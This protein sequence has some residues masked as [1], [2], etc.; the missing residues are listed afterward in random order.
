MSRNTIQKTFPVLRMHCA[1]CAKRIEDALGRLPGV[2]GASVNLAASTAT[3]VYDPKVQN[4]SDIRKAVREEG[5]DL[6]VE[7]RSPADALDEIYAGESDRLRR[8]MLGAVL[9]SLP[10]VVVSM[11]F[12]DIPYAGELM[13]VLATPVVF[14]FGRDFFAGAWAQLKRRSASMDTLVAL[15]TATAYLFSVF[16]TLFPGFWLA[17]GIHPHVYFESAS[18]I[19]AFVLLGRWLEQ[20]ARRR[21]AMSV[22]RLMGLQPGTATVVRGF[23]RYAEVTIGDLVP[24]DVVL[25]KPGMRIAVDG[26]VMTGHS[27]VDESMLTG[28]P[29]PVL[30]QKGNRVFAGTINRNGSLHFEA[31][32]T[33]SNTALAQIIRMVQDAQGSKAPVQKRV[34]RIAAVFV[35]AVMAIAVIALVAWLLFDAQNGLVHGVLALVTVLIVACPCALGLATPAAITVGIGRAAERGILIKDAGSLETARKVSAVVFDK[36]GTVTQGHPAVVSVRWLNGDESGKHILRELE[37]RSEHPLAEAIAGY[38]DAAGENVSPPLAH[39]ESVTGRGVRGVAGGK[40]YLAGSIEWMQENHIRIDES[41]LDEAASVHGQAQI[42]VWFA[43]GGEALALVAVADEIRASSREAVRLLEARHID[44]YMLTGDSLHTARE[45]A[46]QAGIKVF[47]AGMLPHQKVEFIRQLQAQGHVVAMVGDGINDS[48]SLAQ[49][50]LS[51]A[52]GQ[53]SDIAMDV[54]QMTVVPS[55][56]TKV[57][58]AIRLSARTVAVIRQNLFWAFIYNLAG[59]PVAAGIL[60]AVNGFLLNPMIAGG[61]MA[62][63]SLCV[64]CNSL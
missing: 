30:K 9:L 37:R 19:V 17:R 27:Y 1:S 14:W 41:L 20:K 35:P 29:V 11:F 63:S 64:V 52:M 58:E 36:T 54:A 21:A 50:D 12:M 31:V 62:L 39:F 46:A 45:I 59:I 3:V 32:G 8:R 26:V 43:G 28:E 47:R 2:T 23:G 13:W 33:G 15:S 60:Y 44:C 57:V 38:F 55:D 16:N 34:D 53:G 42:A 4:P 40:T 6:L 10:V 56:L 61:A 18:V 5:Y 7:D 48:A 51:I 25:V 24:G 49:A 22:R